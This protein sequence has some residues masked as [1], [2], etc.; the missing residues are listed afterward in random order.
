MNDTSKLNDLVNKSGF[1]LQIGIA[2]LIQRTKDRH[3]CSVLYQEHAWSN[4][5]DDT[6]GFIDIVVQNQHKTSFFILE[7]KRVLDSSWIFLIPSMQ[8][9]EQRNTKAW[10]TNYNDRNSNLNYFGWAFLKS[11]PGMFESQFCIVPGQD[12]KSQP[13]LERISAELVSA[14]EGFAYEERPLVQKDQFAPRTYFNVIVTTAKLQICRFNP[15]EVA[16]DTG[17]IASTAYEEVPYLK[18][19]KQLSTREVN[20]PLKYN[21][22]FSIPEIVQA[23]TSTVFIVNSENLEKFL[24]DFELENDSLIRLLQ[25]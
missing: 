17:T 6:D 10:V 12:A 25:S 15:E 23:K 1:P 14:T 13:M 16:I 2:S 9:R 11:D 5:N 4:K 21:I 19:S 22:S 20:L 7:C 24:C 8:K 3:G 18:F